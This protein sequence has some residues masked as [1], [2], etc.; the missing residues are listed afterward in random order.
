MLLDLTMPELG[1]EE[2]F[3]RLRARWPDLPVVFSSGYSVDGALCDLLDRG[4]VGYIQKPYSL[5]D[6]LLAVRTTLE[7]PLPSA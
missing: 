2:T 4:V 1:G 6:L 7:A 3:E 5:D